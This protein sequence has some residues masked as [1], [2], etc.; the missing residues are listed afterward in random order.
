M[1]D[2][3][4]N[5]IKMCGYHRISAH[6]LACA[7]KSDLTKTPCYGNINLGKRDPNPCSSLVCLGPVCHIL[8]AFAI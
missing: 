1:L 7:I 5:F 4:M 8:R 2:L 3:L 6:F